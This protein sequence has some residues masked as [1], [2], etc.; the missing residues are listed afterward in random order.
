MLAGRGV[1]GW[2]GGGRS[3][4][5]R[6]PDTLTTL[7]GEALELL[8]LGRLRR[9]HLGE[10][11]GDDPVHDELWDPPAFQLVHGFDQA[12]ARLALD[13]EHG[14]G[15]EALGGGRQRVRC[16]VV[17]QVEV[18]HGARLGG[19][20]GDD[21]PGAG[22]TRLG[23]RQHHVVSCDVVVEAVQLLDDL[24][25]RHHGVPVG[26]LR[27]EVEHHLLAALQGHVQHHR[28]AD[29]LVV[30]LS[31][32]LQLA[33][34]LVRHDLPARIDTHRIDELHADCLGLVQH[35]LLLRGEAHGTAG[36]Q[37]GRV[38]ELVFLGHQHHVLEGFDVA[39][40]HQEVDGR[41]VGVVGLALALHVRRQLLHE[42]A[43]VEVVAQLVQERAG[44]VLFDQRLVGV[45][46]WRVLQLELRIVRELLAVLVHEV[47]ALLHEA[48]LVDYLV[49]RRQ[50]GAAVHG[51]RV[52]VC[53]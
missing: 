27:G 50:D 7:L 24:G 21:D 33:P 32:P 28:R 17:L 51:C 43:H 18:G 11:R 16:L 36:L 31:H 30:A 6:S 15:A 39:K 1:L 3:L 23:H 35:R 19:V 42:D 8:V 41:R 5:H 47:L 48:G 52:G 4:L 53:G 38:H 9:H 20:P 2:K 34:G 44:D 12:F 29:E 40:A 46:N 26:A 49:D 10:P 45:V 14:A 22:L 13:G 37:L 25:V